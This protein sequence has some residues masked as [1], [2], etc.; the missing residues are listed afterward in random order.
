MQVVFSD[1]TVSFFSSLHKAMSPHSL[2]DDL[3]MYVAK[4]C[5]FQKNNFSRHLTKIA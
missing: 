2:Q 1:A 3:Y 4:H 5:F